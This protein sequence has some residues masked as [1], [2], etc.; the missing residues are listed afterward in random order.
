M[1]NFV[2]PGET[3]GGYHVF[4]NVDLVTDFMYDNEDDV[5]V[6]N[7]VAEGGSR[8]FSGNL[9]GLFV[10]NGGGAMNSDYTKEGG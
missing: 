3:K 1:A 5:T 7:F 4:I 8:E 9:T 10:Q 6:V 2:G